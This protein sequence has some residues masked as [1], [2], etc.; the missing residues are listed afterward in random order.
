[1]KFGG[2][3]P[4]SPQSPCL[5]AGALKARHYSLSDSF[6]FELGDRAEHVELEPSHR[7]CRV[8]PLRQRYECHRVDLTGREDQ[9][10]T[11][12]QPDRRL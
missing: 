5:R 6:P 9:V 11:D 1:M 3:T 8:D 2:T 4:R 10:S 12:E 7:C